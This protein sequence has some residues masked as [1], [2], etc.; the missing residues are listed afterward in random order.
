[1][2]Q[3]I[4]HFISNHEIL[5]S[6]WIILLIS[7]IFITMKEK[8]SKVKLINRNQAIYLIN[9]KKGIVIDLRSE[10]DFKKGHI[11]NSINLS[12]FEIKKLKK[13]ENKNIILTSINSLEIFS[14]AE[15]LTK[16]GFKNI[17]ILKEGITGWLNDNLPLI[18]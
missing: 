18:K 6:I 13:I 2:I 9:H 5:T 17:Y 12:K 15:K 4:I 1:M 3:N 14:E 10:K 8:F 16:K 7:I 11:I